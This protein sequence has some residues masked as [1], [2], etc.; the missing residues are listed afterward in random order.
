MITRNTQESRALELASKRP[1][2]ESS[3]VSPILTL[4]T[5]TIIAGADNQLPRGGACTRIEQCQH[6]ENKTNQVANHSSEQLYSSP[7]YYDPTRTTSNSMIL[8]LFVLSYDT[9]ILLC[10][11]TALL[12]TAIDVPCQFGVELFRPFLRSHDD[13]GSARHP[14]IH[15]FFGVFGSRFM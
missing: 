1:R 8:L 4:G 9:M 12:R 7:Y 14:P 13:T 10:Y 3:P 11:Q 5:S 15:R 6:L 2:K